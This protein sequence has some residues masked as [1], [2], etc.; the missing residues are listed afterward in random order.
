M[1]IDDKGQKIGVISKE[2]A[3]KR[4]EDVNLDLVEVAPNA[5]PPVCRILNFGKYLYELQKREHEA[6][7][8]QKQ[9]QIQVKIVKFKPK[10]GEHDYQVKLKR[11]KKF[12]G[13]GNKVRAMVYL[14]GRER[15]KPELGFK[16]LYRVRED[17]EEIAAFEREPVR[18]GPNV[19]VSI[20][21]INL[22]GGKKNA[23]N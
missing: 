16:I 14:R 18:E 22:T 12:I 4:A 10:I 1:L 3:L 8:K 9:N 5:K 20:L 2:E 11:I 7:K 15:A 21:P 13:E 17:L 19:S 6:K 23:K